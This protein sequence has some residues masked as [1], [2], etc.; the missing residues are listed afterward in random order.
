MV[1]VRLDLP[2]T[3]ASLGFEGEIGWWWTRGAPLLQIWKTL[4]GYIAVPALFIHA[5]AIQCAYSINAY[6]GAENVGLLMID[7]DKLREF[8]LDVFNGLSE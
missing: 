2:G 3:L 5:K 7:I 4:L 8:S 1:V 6:E